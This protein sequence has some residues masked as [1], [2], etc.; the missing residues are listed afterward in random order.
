MNEGTRTVTAWLLAA[1][2]FTA[3]GGAAI[4]QAAPP[5]SYQ[6]PPA[7]PTP[8]PRLQGP[9]VEDHPVAQPTTDAPTTD[10]PP[11]PPS[12]APLAAPSPTASLRPA[13]AAR[14]ATAPAATTPAATVPAQISPQ[15]SPSSPATTAP[16]V[17][18]LPLPSLAATSA[19]ETPQAP[20]APADRDN[21]WPWYAAA[22]ALAG[23]IALAMWRR[24]HRRAEDAPARA[25]RTL[26]SPPA[27]PLPTQPRQIP[28]QPAPTLDLSLEARRFS[29]TLVNASLDYHLH[30]TNAGAQPLA[31]IAI[32]ADMIGAHASLPAEAQLAQESATFEP[33]HRIAALAPGESAELSGTLRLPLAGA[34]AIRQ[35][36]AA[37]F[38]PLVRLRA[39][40]GTDGP[41][42]ASTH[43]IGEVPMRP[44]SG[45]RPFRLDLGPRIYPE[46]EQRKLAIP[47]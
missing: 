34:T 33:L 21:R 45:L 47:A 8:D 35:G 40:A 19:P 31:D 29:A 42:F 44:G 37:L 4:A 28:A 41:S 39:Q 7:S 43:V 30:V 2:A 24:A 18:P 46:I 11:P 1:L 15:P 22:L 38:V 26:P 5:S 10:A 17:T 12:A 9:V 6:L 14:R 27:G 20:A 23:G 13:P 36:T 3:P 32:G 25:L 16:E